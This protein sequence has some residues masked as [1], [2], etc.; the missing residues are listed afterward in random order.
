MLPERWQQIERLYHDA[1][2]L[3]PG[4][5][6]A[7]LDRVCAGDD[8]L[9]REIESLL[10]SHDQAASFIEAPPDDV[11]AGMM[12]EEQAHS[13]I[14]RTLGHYQIQSLL[15][16]GGMGEVY[17][18]HDT[19]LDRDVAVKI[20][21]EHSDKDSEAL[22][23][24]E[25][26]A[27]AVAA[28][29]HPNILAIH[30]FGTEQS[31]S[32]AVMELL[33][34]EPLRD[35][36]RRSALNWREAV[37]IGIA[38]AEGL[39]AAHARGIIHRDLKP[40]NIFLTTS[41]Q[42]KILDFGIARVKHTVTPEAET[43]TG[44]A[45]KPGTIMGTIAYMSPEQARGEV[46]DAPSDIFS[47]GSMLYEMAAGRRPFAGATATEMMAAILRDDP[48]PLAASVAS[49][50]AVPAE[51]ERVIRH[52]LE[53]RASERYQSARDLAADLKAVLSGSGKSITAPAIKRRKRGLSVA[54]TILALVTAV[55]GYFAWKGSVPAVEAAGIV[56]L[57]TKVY[58]AQEFGYLTD[59]IPGTLST[60]LAQVEGLETKTP[61][62]SFEVERMHGDIGKV[63]ELYG[64]KTCVISSVTAEA[65]RFVLGVQLVEP[66]SRRVLWSREYEGRRGNYIELARQAADG[67]RRALK[68]DAPQVIAGASLAANSEAELA[69]RQ[70]QY[71]W[72]RYNNQRQPADFDLALASL[73]RALELDPKLAD[74][75]AHIATLFSFK[76]EVGAP[77]RDMLPEIES[78][79]RRAVEINPRCSKGWYALSW[80][81]FSRMEN[82]KALEYGLKAVF[83]GPQEPMALIALS[84]ASWSFELQLATNVEARR[85]D[86]LYLPP[87]FNAANA[88]ENL[89]RSAEGVPLI[90]EG[91][92]IEP[93]M[94]FGLWEK[95]MLLVNLG[96]LG[97]AAEL[98][99]R[100]EKPTA[101]NRF[102]TFLFACAQQALALEQG[103]TKAAEA[104]L[105]QILKAV[106][107]PRTSSL[108]LGWISQ[109]AVPFLARH[110]K[111][112]TAFQILNRTLDAGFV[113]YYDSLMLDPRLAPLRADARFHKIQARARAQFDE[114]LKTLEQARD[115]GELPPYLEAAL[116][117]LVKKLGIR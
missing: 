65:D 88:L 100:L 6:L 101:E 96:R 5:R 85:L 16:A 41:G 117:G 53:K 19:R 48:P 7:F 24:F 75:A 46:A 54:L 69:F 111:T 109:A 9:R 87:L 99:K 92:R 91:L 116:A 17:R 67:I 79:G 25:R 42:V 38:I 58:G 20:L 63:A 33:E 56:A 21:P 103:D 26:E 110:G 14:G 106:N 113:P 102:P 44:T 70:G 40:E 66:R 13:M 1:L 105:G 4:H 50:K 36:L 62:T 82:S 81:A 11:V 39:A 107:D 3:A 29:S 90:D 97:E 34:G 28:L 112:D 8:E 76:Y 83:V 30:D 80:A 115:R 86:P 18:A 61:P 98:V 93:D 68:P 55:I 35:H 84:N 10:A 114:V 108:D 95:A 64:V 15:G 47:F 49:G 104:A 22:R 31:V 94:P 74:A 27:K 23:R 73:K 32:Y 71:L 2:E 51:L 43:V 77:L 52:C 72:N 78:W 59:A 37:E 12:A 57:P 45:T 60:H 89:G